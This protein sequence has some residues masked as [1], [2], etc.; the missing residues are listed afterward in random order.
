[1]PQFQPD[2]PEPLPIPPPIKA[3]PENLEEIARQ[4][5]SQRK[6]RT[7]RSDFIIDPMSQGLN[8]PG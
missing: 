8:I 5:T 1:M 4:R 7:D 3:P 2:K 6:K